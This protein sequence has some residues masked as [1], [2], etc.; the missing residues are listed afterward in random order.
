MLDRA[1]RLRPIGK[2]SLLQFIP[3]MQAITSPFLSRPW[4]WQLH[5]TPAHE[6]GFST[7]GDIAELDAQHAFFVR[8]DSAR[9]V[10]ISDHSQNPLLL[11]T[12]SSASLVLSK[13]PRS[14]PDIYYSAEG[15]RHEFSVLVA[16][17][18]ALASV[19]VRTRSDQWGRVRFG[20]APSARSDSRIGV[21][22]V[23]LYHPGAPHTA[24]DAGLES[25]QR[26]LFGTTRIAQGAVTGI[27]WE[28]YG[29]LP[30]EQ[31]RLRL[32][33]SGTQPAS[34]ARP[35]VRP[36]IGSDQPAV[37]IEWSD[38]PAS[39]NTITPRGTLLDLSRLAPG[40][41]TLELRVALDGVPPAS[42]SRVIEIV[43][44]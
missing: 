19:E 21:S 23:V 10:V 26:Y 34:T 1:I 43:H 30:G 8:G 35:D 44:R 40:W 22:D 20:V 9:L 25:I 28:V 15:S 3:A 31:P 14:V 5:Q 6:L 13:S 39:G 4:D 42:T 17:D 18:S 12:P 2:G 29:L 7:V 33:V 41:Y 38:S 27:F 36:A 11:R 16:P 37:S 32:T 24:P